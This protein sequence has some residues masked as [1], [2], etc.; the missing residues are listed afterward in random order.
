MKFQFKDFFLNKNKLKKFILVLTSILVL[1]SITYNN[2]KIREIKRINDISE[3]NIINSKEVSSKEL[4]LDSWQIIKSN[5]YK[6]NLNKQNWNK[7]KKR[8]IH[9]IKT[10]EDAYVAINTMLASLDDSY[11]K[12]MSKEEFMAQNSAIN[13][14]LY[15]IGINIASISGKIYIINVLENAPAYIAG[16]RSGD[17]ILKVNGE[18]VNGQTIYHVA[19][20]I[21]GDVNQSLELELLRGSEKFSKTVKREEIKIKTIDYKKITDNIGYIRVSSFIGA[22][23]PKEFIIALN[24]LKDSKGLIL[25]LRGNSGGLFQN[26]IMISNLFMKKG[27][28]V[29]VIARQG[30][31]NVYSAQSA[32]CIY[33]NPVVVLID[34][35]SAS[36]SEILSSALRDNSRA[37]LV[38]T[39]TYGKGLVQKIF[40][41]PNQSGMNLTIARYLTPKGVDINKKGI[42]PDFKVTFSHNDFINNID[43]QLLYAQRYLEKRIVSGL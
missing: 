29:N 19:Q 41:L 16:V 4:F 42:E 31:K 7:W 32:G 22:D 8:Y 35:S 11:S 39:R 1:F 14:K 6:N 21:R 3:V 5:Y 34:N 12:F 24:R 25:D 40:S 43:P 33:E 13:S 37:V 2:Y 20:L 28:I 38:G 23:T 36:A 30:K 26:A 17:I 10:D 18:D 9:Q 27:V 15:G